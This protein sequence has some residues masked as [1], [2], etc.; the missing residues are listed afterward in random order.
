MEYLVDPPTKVKII[1]LQPKNVFGDQIWT[2]VVILGWDITNSVEAE[3]AVSRNAVAGK[4]KQPVRHIKNHSICYSQIEGFN[5]LFIDEAKVAWQP[6]PDEMKKFGYKIP[7][8]KS[9]GKNDVHRITKK[10]YE[11]LLLKPELVPGPLWGKSLYNALKRNARW[12][13]IRKQVLEIASGKCQISQG[14]FEKG[15]ICHEKW[16]YNESSLTATLTGFELVCPDCNFVLHYGGSGQIIIGTSM[17]NPEKAVEL[18]VRRDIH[19]EKINRLSREQC[20]R[21]LSH[22]NQEHSR[23][24]KKRRKVKISQIIR[25]QSPEIKGI[26]IR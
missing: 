12:R 10:Y 19:M 22:A 3:I 16:D 13:K 20:N 26:R 25:K 7:R 23:R 8:R 6:I 4:F 17:N 2:G 1:N 5:F 24:S 15:M 18:F 14:S 21:I 11:E 9:W